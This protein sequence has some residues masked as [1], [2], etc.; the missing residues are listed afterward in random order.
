MNTEVQCKRNGVIRI[1]TNQPTCHIEE[2]LYIGQD[3]G[4]CPIRDGKCK[5]GTNFC[6]ILP[7]ASEKLSA[8]FTSDSHEHAITIAESF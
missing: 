4:K 5:Q 3:N 1:V 6:I 8:C 7:R 2:L